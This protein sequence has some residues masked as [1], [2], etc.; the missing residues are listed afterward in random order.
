MCV[1]TKSFQ[2]CLSLCH[3]MDRSLPGS[4]VHGILQAR[5]LEWVPMSSYR[6]S[7]WPRIKP[8]SLTSPTL[9]GGSFTISA[10]WEAQTAYSWVLFLDSLWQSLLFN[11]FF[12]NHDV[13]S[14]Y[15]YNQINIYCICYCFCYS[16]SLFL[17][18]YF[19][20]LLSFVAWSE[21]SVEK[22]ILFLSLSFL[23]HICD[24]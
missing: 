5:I 14:G 22:L 8:A 13:Q 20:L 24:T 16:Y 2:S 21:H 15:W 10:T 11:C 1:C 9:A 6:G 12:L 18:L 17:Y 4:S 7:S 3:P 19:T 23:K